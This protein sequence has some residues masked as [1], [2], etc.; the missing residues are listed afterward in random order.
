MQVYELSKSVYICLRL[1]VMFLFVYLTLEEKTA[2]IE[3]CL[4]VCKLSIYR[5][6]ATPEIYFAVQ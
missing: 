3:L 2:N 1:I 5:E 4:M 6:T